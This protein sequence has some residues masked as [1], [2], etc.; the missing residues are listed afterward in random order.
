MQD[1]ICFSLG[2]WWTFELFLVVVVMSPITVFG[3]CLHLAAHLL[4]L[5]QET[6]SLGGL[7]GLLLC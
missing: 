1:I 6:S 7:V 2:D 5:F 3:V 4:T